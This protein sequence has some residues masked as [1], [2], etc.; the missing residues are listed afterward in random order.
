MNYVFYFAVL[1]AFVSLVNA[2]TQ[3]CNVGELYFPHAPPPPGQRPR[4]DTNNLEG[5]GLCNGNPN[6]N[7][8]KQCDDYCKQQYGTE[9]VGSECQERFNK[10]RECVCKLKCATGGCWGDPHCYSFDGLK[11]GY[12]GLC[13]HALIK[14]KTKYNSLPQ[15]DVRQTNR[16]CDINPQLSVLDKNELRI[17]EW[18]N[19]DLVIQTPS[20]QGQSFSLTANGQSRT[21]PY[22]YEKKERAFYTHYVSITY[23]DAAKQHLV[24]ETSFGLRILI[25]SIQSAT[26]TYADIAVYIPRH[27]DLKGK[28]WGLLGRWNDDVSDD[29]KDSKEVKQ[30][31]DDFSWAYGNSWCY[32]NNGIPSDADQKN[33]AA[34]HKKHRDA[35]INDAKKKSRLAALC[36]RLQT[37]AAKACAQRLGRVPPSVDDCI[38]DVSYGK[39]EQHEKEICDTILKKFTC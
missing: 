29:D 33:I 24:V 18:D 8:N 17:P 39:N 35:T 30:P 19:L 14:P 32:S 21:I 20:K 25:S 38:T 4:R 7:R 12:Q 36:N 6:A 27:P 13:Q 5:P 11:F 10:K 22:R 16:A 26:F 9:Y 15:F 23:Q 1:I 34:Q 2:Q 3:T 37:P 28:S 31:L